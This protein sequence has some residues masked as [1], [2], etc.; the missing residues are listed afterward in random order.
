L[1]GDFWEMNGGAIE[2]TYALGRNLAGGK[3]GER[4]TFCKNKKNKKTKKQKNKKTE[5]QREGHPGVK[6]RPPA[7]ACG[8][9]RRQGVDFM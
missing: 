1:N 8:T 6:A 5:P 9:G 3:R 7:E 2:A 4:P